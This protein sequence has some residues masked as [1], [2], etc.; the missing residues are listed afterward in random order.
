MP[1]DIKREY[2]VIL[3]RLDAHVVLTPDPVAARKFLKQAFSSL[4]MPEAELSGLS[5]EDKT[6]VR[7]AMLEQ[8][9]HQAYLV[10]TRAN[11]DEDWQTT[12]HL[13]VKRGVTGYL[14]YDKAATADEK[15]GD[16][17][18]WGKWD[19]SLPLWMGMTSGRRESIFTE[20]D[21]VK[22]DELA[23]RR[24]AETP[25]VASAKEAPL[26]KALAR[27]NP[28]EAEIRARGLKRQEGVTA[29][30]A[31]FARLTIMREKLETTRPSDEVY[32]RFRADAGIADG[33]KWDELSAPEQA[34]FAALAS[35]ALFAEQLYIHETG[36]TSKPDDV[37]DADFFASRRETAASDAETY[38]ASSKRSLA[39]EDVARATE[40]EPDVDPT[41]GTRQTTARGGESTIASEDAGSAPG[42]AVPPWMAVYERAIDEAGKSGTFQSEKDAVLARLKS[43]QSDADRFLASAMNAKTKGGEPLDFNTVTW[44]GRNQESAAYGAF[45]LS[46][47]LLKEAAATG[48]GTPP[49]QVA[50][51][52]IF[53]S[54]ELQY[55]AA[56][57]HVEKLLATK[58]A[59]GKSLAE[60][61]PAERADALATAYRF[62]VERVSESYARGKG[63][64]A[65]RGDHWTAAVAAPVASEFARTPAP[66]EQGTPPKSEV[67]V[68]VAASETLSVPVPTI[69]D[70]DSYRDAVK[71][72]AEAEGL[73][74]SDSQVADRARLEALYRS[75]LSKVAGV[76]DPKVVAELE[77]RV[78]ALRRITDGSVSMTAIEMMLAKDGQIVL[79]PS[80]RATLARQLGLEA[81]PKTGK[82][83]DLVDVLRG[84]AAEAV[85]TV[86]AS[87]GKGA[88]QAADAPATAPP[89]ASVETK[90][91]PATVLAKVIS[92]LKRDAA[93]TGKNSAYNLEI[94]GALEQWFSQ[95]AIG[96]RAAEIADKLGKLSGPALLDRAVNLATSAEPPAGASE[97]VRFTDMLEKLTESKAPKA[98]KGN[99]LTGDGVSVNTS[100]NRAARSELS[101]GV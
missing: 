40:G 4:G 63:S 37:S 47:G 45:W 96:S 52:E 10:R 99:E 16:T 65:S 95:P 33:K 30:P 32:D 2:Q 57:A 17:A 31:E 43:P 20:D 59:N 71:R 6:R 3:D 72:R 5:R 13:A 1:D 98:A 97:F 74:L 18:A 67:P 34:Y 11:P 77:K 73:A 61:P 38:Y 8:L 27:E 90:A 15:L 58:L 100:V 12:W 48:I 28:N 22:I 54:P 55:Q 35:H 49:R 26:T 93:A 50:V 19:A 64:R 39:R 29:D 42:K 36:G 25:E 101:L 23:R 81:D 89:S 91:S 44:K 46:H 75:V 21:W 85:E 68:T 41:A 84:K 62:G 76:T 82:A 88:I 56:R 70:A 66:T 24:D 9:V 51:E 69:K 92:D 94:A 78:P 79:D 86:K 80:T 87:E 83:A 60:L 53:A 7:N 14:E